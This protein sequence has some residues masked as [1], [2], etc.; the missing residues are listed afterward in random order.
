MPDPV[1]DVPVAA[2]SKI[3]CLGKNYAAH[4]AE[5]GAEVPEEPIVFTKLRDTLL[6]HGAPI[7]LPHWVETRIDHELE[8]GVILGF[9]DP[10][11]RGRK[12]VAAEHALE[13]VGGYTILNDVTARRMQGDDR[14]KQHPWLRCK[15]FD[16]FCPIGPWVVPRTELPEANALEL[17]LEVDGAERQRSNTSLMVT[18][19][20]EAIAFLSRHTTL[21]PGDVIATGTPAGVGPLQPGNVV[22]CVIEH[23]GV[24]ANP[25]IREPQ[26]D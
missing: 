2:P 26:P 21:R 13:L 17:W 23:L 1:F 18:G 15:S 22:R 6:P 24:L 7:V 9:T 20:A 16:T 25:V 14:A 11:R 4:A 12:Y 10:Q 8:L 5:F 19:I 3:L